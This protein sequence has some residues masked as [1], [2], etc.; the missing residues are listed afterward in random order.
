MI[1][2]KQLTAFLR[3]LSLYKIDKRH[4]QFLE[5]YKNKD[6]NG[7]NV[8]F[9]NYYLFVL[10]KKLDTRLIDLLDCHLNYVN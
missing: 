5:Y 7:R 1:T 4:K 6:I 2:K 8:F 3:L 9:H 10:I